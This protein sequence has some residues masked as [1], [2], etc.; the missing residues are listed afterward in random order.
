MKL[1]GLE[2]RINHLEYAKE[3]V[4][5]LTSQHCQVTFI[6]NNLE[7]IDLDCV[8]EFIEVTES[9]TDSISFLKVESSLLNI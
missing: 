4:N 1:L 5:Y 6:D 8:I 9:G 3:V 2:S 7:T